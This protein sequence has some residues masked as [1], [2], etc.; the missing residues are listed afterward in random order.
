MY[1]MTGILDSVLRINLSLWLHD[2]INLITERKTHSNNI[3]ER[4]F[5]KQISNAVF[6]TTMANVR[7]HQKYDVFMDSQRFCTWLQALQFMDSL[8]RI[9]KH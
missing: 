3:F 5:F 7:E 9:R 6:E 8:I 4:N 2:H 1:C